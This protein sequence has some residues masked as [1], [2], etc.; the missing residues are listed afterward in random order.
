MVYGDAYWK[1]RSMAVG[2]NVIDGNRKWW[3]VRADIENKL[4]CS[5]ATGMYIVGFLEEKQLKDDDPVLSNSTV[6]VE[7]RPI[8][9]DCR[10]RRDADGGTYVRGQHLSEIAI[11][12]PKPKINHRPL[13]HGIP[14]SELRIAREDEQE[15]AY[16]KN[17]KYYIKKE[18]PIF[19][20]PS[21]TK[22]PFPNRLTIKNKI[23]S[24]HDYRLKERDVL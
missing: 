5:A 9:L 8:I 10:D 4:G 17:G 16:L 14:M 6:I 18:L 22:S 2:L 3:M 11:A 24:R 20:P 15:R 19:K 13:P 23:Y 1:L 7:R 12:P 21:I